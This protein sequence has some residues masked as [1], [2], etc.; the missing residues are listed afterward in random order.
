MPNCFNL[1]RIGESEPTPL[2][3]I[4]DELCREVGHR[5]PDDSN[6]WFCNWYNSVGLALACGRSFDDL[7]EDYK[8]E[9]EIAKNII[10]YLESNFI[11]KCWYESR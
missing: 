3:Q 6:Q 1:T 8:D 4:D 11:P 9:P 2:V 7:V 5:E 10:S